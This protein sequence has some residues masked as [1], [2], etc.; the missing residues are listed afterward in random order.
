MMA[1]RQ[2][3]GS[4]PSVHA[5][6]QGNPYWWVMLIRRLQVTLL[7]TKIGWQRF[8]PG[9]AGRLLSD[10]V[11]R[12]GIPRMAELFRAGRGGHAAGDSNPELVHPDRLLSRVIGERAAQVAE[13]PEVGGARGPSTS[14][15][16]APFLS[17]RTAYTSVCTATSAPKNAIF[18]SCDER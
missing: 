15:E 11:I 18:A 2:G 17:C 12:F 10:R 14:G 9:L 3:G 4:V 5:D 16:D 7:V 1:I 8:W 13:E 6:C